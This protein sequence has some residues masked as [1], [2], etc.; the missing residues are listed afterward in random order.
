MA[1]Q[2]SPGLN[3]PCAYDK[4]NPIPQGIGLVVPNGNAATGQ[5]LASQVSSAQIPRNVHTT[6]AGAVD[7]NA[8][9]ALAL[10][11]SDGGRNGSGNS[12]GPAGLDTL[13][14]DSNGSGSF[15]AGG[16]NQTEGP[17]SG[18]SNQIVEQTPGGLT[19]TGNFG[20]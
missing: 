3:A 8:G 2:C 20:G 9:R 12:P 15:G 1:T 10:T 16:A 19:L 17:T 6:S 11:E 7:S 5:T 4:V 13:N 18:Q 14:S